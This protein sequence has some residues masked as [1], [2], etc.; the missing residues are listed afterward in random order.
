[1][2]DPIDPDAVNLLHEHEELG[3]VT[4]NHPP[5]GVSPARA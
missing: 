4:V 2:V 1:M 5:D 3:E